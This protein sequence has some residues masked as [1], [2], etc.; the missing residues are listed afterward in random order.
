MNKG[1]LIT[2]TREALARGRK[3]S[4]IAR[5]VGVTDS[6]LRGLLS[7]NKDHPG[8]S[9]GTK[10]GPWSGA[11]ED[12]L[13]REWRRGT[14][15][16]IIAERLNRSQ[17]AVK[18]ARSVLGLP[19]RRQEVLTKINVYISPEMLR[20]V[21]TKRTVDGVARSR[22]IANALAHYLGAV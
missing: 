2:Y 22:V 13:A 4:Q 20:K 12:Q 3:Y 8:E 5:D 19:P 9:V 7:K 1:Q 16:A 15:I 6:Y 17:R 21:D 14:S 18:E 11:E 10:K